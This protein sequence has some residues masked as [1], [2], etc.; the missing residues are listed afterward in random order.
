MESR[1]FF[2]EAHPGTSTENTTMG[3]NISD[4]GTCPSKL[5]SRVIELLVET[6]RVPVCKN[7][8]SRASEVDRQFSYKYFHKV[9]KNEE[10]F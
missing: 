3:F 6:K 1:S 8:K 7:F 4:A 2:S 10:N 9:L 5:I